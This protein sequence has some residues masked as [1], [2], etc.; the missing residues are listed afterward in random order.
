LSDYLVQRDRVLVNRQIGIRVDDVEKVGV[1]GYAEIECNI[2]F[3]AA[4]ER[5]VAR[6]W[7]RKPSAESGCDIGNIGVSLVV[8]NDCLFSLLKF[9]IECSMS[10]AEIVRPI[11]RFKRDFQNS[12]TIERDGDPSLY[13]FERRYAEVQSGDEVTFYAARCLDEWSC[14]KLESQQ[15]RWI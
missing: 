9:A 10:S 11:N 6:G 13:P 12:R 4:V 14:G 3:E 1:G 5:M 8:K 15:A 2:C 7:R